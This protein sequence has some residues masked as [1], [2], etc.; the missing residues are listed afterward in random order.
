M[1]RQGIF[2]LSVYYDLYGKK[3]GHTHLQQ[4]KRSSASETQTAAYPD[5]AVDGAAAAAAATC[6]T[7]PMESKTR[8]AYPRDFRRCRDFGSAENEVPFKIN[9]LEQFPAAFSALDKIS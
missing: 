6:Q 1:G 5:A 2:S 8:L 7:F 9:S 4:L 3:A